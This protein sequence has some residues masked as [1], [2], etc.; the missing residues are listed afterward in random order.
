MGIIIQGIT[1]ATMRGLMADERSALRN[2]GMVT[3]GSMDIR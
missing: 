3:E 1:L 2:F